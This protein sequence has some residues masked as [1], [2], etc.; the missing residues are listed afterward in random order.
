VWLLNADGTLAKIDPATGEMI[1]TERV[2]ANAVALAVGQGAIWVA[3]RGGRQLERSK[4][5]SRLEPTDRFSINVPDN[6]CALNTLEIDCRIGLGFSLRTPDGIRASYHGAWR[7]DRI[8]GREGM[9]QGK[10]FQGPLT[11]SSDVRRDAGAGLV[12][13]ERWGTLALRWERMVVIAE[14]E[15]G[16]VAGGPVCGEGTGTWIAIAGPLKGERGT[17]EFGGPV[18]ES[19]AL[20]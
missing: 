11:A 5:P 14:E 9:C 12:W 10:T 13:I 18:P 4:L 2:G 20:G 7:E 1:A 19:F 15:P 6:D 17:F 8:R 16:G 3:V